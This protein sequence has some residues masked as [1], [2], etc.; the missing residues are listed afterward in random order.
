MN[1]EKNLSEDECGKRKCTTHCGTSSAVYGLGLIG[2]A[3]YYI[4]N[5]ESF[6]IGA[7]GILKA[8][9]WPAFVVYK[10]LEFLGM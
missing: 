4:Q 1:D 7:L 6:W 8:I 5:A 10:L 9:I 3:I 2:A